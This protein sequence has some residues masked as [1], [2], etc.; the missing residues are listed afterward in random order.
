VVPGQLGLH[1]VLGDPDAPAGSGDLALEVVPRLPADGAF[2]ALAA[3]PGTDLARLQFYLREGAGTAFELLL[4][5]TTDTVVPEPST[6]LF[7]GL[8]LASLATRR[9]R[10]MGGARGSARGITIPALSG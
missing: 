8:S 5:R 3:P 4:A 9:D 7:L 1:V 6:A 2:L 10:F